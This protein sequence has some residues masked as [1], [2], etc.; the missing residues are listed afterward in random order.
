MGRRRRTVLVGLVAAIYVA[1]WSG[2]G[3]EAVSSAGGRV[4][5]P[6]YAFDDSCSGTVTLDMPPGWQAGDH[7]H[8]LVSRSH[9]GV[10]LA[11]TCQSRASYREMGYRGPWKAEAVAGWRVPPDI[12]TRRVTVDGRPAVL[13]DRAI[14]LAQVVQ[15]LGLSTVVGD[16]YVSIGI[17]LNDAAF[18]PELEDELVALVT[19]ATI[20]ATAGP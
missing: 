11:A 4:T 1:A 5:L 18:F 14:Q 7:P 15:Y 2:C 12:G 10:E 13:R 9:G 6:L 8:Q 19:S 17:T 3:T 20:G 16:V